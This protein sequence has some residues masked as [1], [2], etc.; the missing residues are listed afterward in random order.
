M[1]GEKYKAQMFL[2]RLRDAGYSERHSREEVET[3][4]KRRITDRF[5]Y[6]DVE[7]LNMFDTYP[8][9]AARNA[10]RPSS[11]GKNVIL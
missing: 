10:G 4:N 5:Q 3:A 1:G 6:S 7:T 9:V 8:A 11:F 2:D